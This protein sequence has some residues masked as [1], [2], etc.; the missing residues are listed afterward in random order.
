MLVEPKVGHNSVI[1]NFV[2]KWNKLPR[3]LRRE[4]SKT[5]FTNK[6]KKN[7]DERKKKD[8]NRTQTIST[9]KNGGL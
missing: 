7:I 1:R 2:C 3:A 4:K 5:K 8:A 6:L 9:G